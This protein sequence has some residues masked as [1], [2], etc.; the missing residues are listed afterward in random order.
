MTLYNNKYRIEPARLKNWDYRNAGP[1]FITI[2]VKDRACHFG[3]CSDGK[4]ILNEV[5][6]IA[7][8][9]WLEIPDHFPY[10]SLGEFVIMPNHTHGILILDSPIVETLQCNVST[11]KKQNQFMSGISPKSGSVSTI[12][13]SYKSACTKAINLKFPELHFKWQERFHDRIIRNYDEFVKIENYIINNPQNWTE[14][15]FYTIK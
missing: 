12:I 6:Q 3:R 4:M 10:V 15:N 2:C 8:K 1:Y 5:G 7:Y 9:Y 13:R 11:D 14:D